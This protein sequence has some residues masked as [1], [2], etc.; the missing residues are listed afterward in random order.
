MGGTTLYALNS[1]RREP[2]RA[3]RYAIAGARRSRFFK[4]EWTPDGPRWYFV[5]DRTGWW[6]LYR[7]GLERG[8]IEAVAPMEAEFGQPQWVFGM[9]SYAFAGDD[10]V[11]CS[12][13]LQGL[14]GLAAIDLD[15]GGS[16]PLDLPCTDFSSVRAHGD[17]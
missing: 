1:T 14:D 10:R 4:P 7:C 3:H 11:V 17:R 2:R 12:Y 13:M 16:T 9:S 15:S 6:N 8:K 5:S